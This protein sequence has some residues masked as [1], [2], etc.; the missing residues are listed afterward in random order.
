MLAIE[1][2]TLP[3]PRQRQLSNKNLIKNALVHVCL[4]GKVNEQVKKDVLNVN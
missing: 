3:I 4:A 2:K 1:K